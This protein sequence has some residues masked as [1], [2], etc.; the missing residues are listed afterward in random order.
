MAARSPIRKNKK[1]ENIT[2][3]IIM[4]TDLDDHYMEYEPTKNCYLDGRRF[5]QVLAF[6]HGLVPSALHV[7]L[8]LAS[9]SKGKGKEEHTEKQ[10][11][12]AMKWDPKKI[13]KKVDTIFRVIIKIKDQTTAMK[14]SDVMIIQWSRKNIVW[15][16]SLKSYKY[17]E[18]IKGIVGRYLSQWAN[19]SI[20]YINL[21]LPDVNQV[22]CVESGFCNA[23]VL[24]VALDYILGRDFDWNAR[25]A[26]DSAMRFTS[27]VEKMYGKLSG[28]PEAEYGFGGLLV[29]GL[30]GTA[31]GYSIA[32]SQDRDRR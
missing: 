32:K 15:I 16:S 22:G 19:F 31:V 7:G 6:Y 9:E 3:P 1:A 8:E 23:Y 21:G 10:E 17:Q 5:N 13:D 4:A 20:E 27:A 2:D 26:K 12:I 18:M 30:V 24:K 14:H 29:G 25:N 11:Y 28:A